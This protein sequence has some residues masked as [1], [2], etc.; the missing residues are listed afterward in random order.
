MQREVLVAR[1]L[2]DGRAEV[3]MDRPSACG[4]SC[5][6]CGGCAG[7]RA[8]AV[9]ENPLDARPGDTVVIEGAT[10]RL[11]GMTAMVYLMP[12]ALL[13]GGWLLGEALQMPALGAVVGLLLGVMLVVLYGRRE[14]HRPPVYRIIAKR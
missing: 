4:G 13:L 9:A 7:S 1:L 8:T 10:T 14:A 12:L 2:P 11:L 6:T 3:V 5:E